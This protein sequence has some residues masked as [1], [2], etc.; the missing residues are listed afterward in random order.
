MKMVSGISSM[1]RV[2]SWEKNMGK[3]SHWPSYGQAKPLDLQSRKCVGVKSDLRGTNLLC[4]CS[5]AVT[6]I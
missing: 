4:K 5:C 2:N 6:F 1:I 3:T